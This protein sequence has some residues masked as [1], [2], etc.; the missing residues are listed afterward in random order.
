MTDVLVIGARPAGVLAALG[1]AERGAQIGAGDEWRLNL[2][3]S[4]NHQ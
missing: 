4:E 1:A 2:R 3:K